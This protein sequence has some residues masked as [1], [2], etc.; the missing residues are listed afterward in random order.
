MTE[1]RKREKEDD[2]RWIEIAHNRGEGHLGVMHGICVHAVE[3]HLN[4]VFILCSCAP[5]DGG[6]VGPSD[7]RK[8]SINQSSAGGGVRLPHTDFPP[9]SLGGDVSDGPRP[10]QLCRTSRHVALTRSN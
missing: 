7:T 6:S 10:S 4:T 3:M 5:C 1:K 9:K 8:T 2:W